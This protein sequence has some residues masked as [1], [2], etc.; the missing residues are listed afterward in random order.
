MALAIDIYCFVFS[1]DRDRFSS[2]CKIGA[3]VENKQNTGKEEESKEPNRGGIRDNS[4]GNY[5]IEYSLHS[6]LNVI[7]YLNMIMVIKL[8]F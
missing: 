2:E 8:L 6:S 7:I 1:L 5:D 3:S 4:L